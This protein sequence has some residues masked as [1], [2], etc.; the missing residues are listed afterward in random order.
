MFI[1]VDVSAGL[2]TLAFAMYVFYFGKML[3]TARV[4]GHPG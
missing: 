2:W 1:L 4:D 3:V